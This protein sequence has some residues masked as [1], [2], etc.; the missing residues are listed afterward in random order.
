MSFLNFS[1]G[2]E[3]LDNIE[4]PSIEDISHDC[5]VAVDTFTGASQVSVKIL[6]PTSRHGFGP[7]LTL[8]NSSGRRQGIFGRGWSLGGIP[9]IGID[10]ENGLPAY[11]GND[12]FASSIA[13]SL[14]FKRTAAGDIDRRIEAGF[15]VEIL[16]A[17]EE[18]PRLRFERWTELATGDVHWRTRDTVDTY[19]FYGRSPASRIA[20]P[21]N[22]RRVFQ[23]LPELSVSARGD[24][25]AYDYAA[26]DLLGGAGQRLADRSRRG[27]LAQRY[28]K[29][30][31]WGNHRPV[32]NA[33]GLDIET[34]TWSFTAVFDYGD[35]DEQEPEVAPE[36][37]WRI[38]PDPF[39]GGAAGFDLRTWR[40]CHR[41]L[42]FH[43]F[44]ALG[45]TPVLTNATQFRYDERPD[46][47]Q[48]IGIQ[49][50]G[51]R[52]TGAARRSQSSPETVFEYTAPGHGAAFTPVPRALEA[53]APA[54]HASSKTL[55]VDLLGEGLPGILQDDRSGWFFQRNLGGGRFASPVCVQSRPAHSLASVALGDFDVDGNINATVLSGQGAGTYSFDRNTETWSSFVP[56]QRMPVVDGRAPIERLDLT[57][58]GQADLVIRT[59]DGLRIHT[60]DGSRGF[61]KAARDVRL[62]AA[63]DGPAGQPPLG[64]D[65]QTDYL[66][67]DMTGD[68]LPDQVLVRTGMVAYWPNLGW[69]RFGAPVIMENAPLL[70]T[71]GRFAIDRVLL[72]DLD[73]SGTA[74]LI[75]LGEGRLDIWTN[76]AGNG[77]VTPRSLTGLPIID[78]FSVLDIIDIAGDGR[79]SL[80]WTEKRKGRT[81]SYQTL[82][83]SAGVPP[84]LIA[85][86]SNGMGRVDRLEYGYST[87]HY[88][89]DMAGQRAW[90]TRLPTH[91]VVVDRHIVEDLIGNT[92]QDTRFQYRNGVYS[93][94]RRRFAGFAEVDT[95]SADFILSDPGPLPSCQPLL[96][97]HFFDQGEGIGHAQ[98]YWQG[99]PE[100]VDLPAFEMD[101]SA[102]T[103]VIDPQTAVEARQSLR[104]RPLREEKFVVLE[105]GPASVPLAVAQTGYVVRIEQAAARAAGAR[106][107]RRLDRAVVACMERETVRALYEGVSNDPRVQHGLIL[108]RDLHGSVLVSTQ[109]AY[110][111]RAGVPAEDDAQQ[112]LGCVVERHDIR[113]DTSDTRHALHLALVDESF[114]ISGLAAPPS[115]YFTFDEARTLVLAAIATPVPHH[116]TPLAGQALRIGWVRNFYCNA[117]GDAVLPFGD[118]AH[119]A[120]LHHVETAAFSTDFAVSHYGAGISSRLPGLGYRDEFGHWWQSSQAQTYLD[121]DGFFL[122]SGTRLSDG[123]P[124][125]IAYDDAGLFPATVTDVFGAVSHTEYDYVALKPW[126]SEMPT[127]AWSETSFDALGIAVRRSHGGTVVDAGGATQAYGFEPVFDAAAI[128]IATALA[129]PAAALGDVAE[130]LLYDF[131]AF[132]RD[133]S[134]PKSVHLRATD[135]FHDGQ[136]GRQDSGSPPMI[137]VAYRDGFGD[138]I[139]TKRQ[140]EAGE[141]IARGGDG[142]VLLDGAGAPSLQVTAERWVASGWQRQNGKGETVTLFDPYFSDRVDFEDDDVLTSFGRPTRVFYD[143]L[144]RM[145]ETQLPDGAIER[146]VYGAW[147]KQHFDANDTI[148][149]SA[150]RL[151]RVN[152]PASHPERHAL[153]VT[154][155]HAST[156]D[157]QILDSEGREVRVQQ[158]DGLGGAREQRVVHTQAGGVDRT[159]DGRGIEVLRLMQDMAGRT[160][161]Q[162]LADV[163]E[164]LTLYD[165]RDNA[166]ET[167]DA[168]AVLRQSSFDALDRLVAVDLD[169]GSG[170]RRIFDVTFADD[171]A[172]AAVIARNLLGAPVRTRDEGGEHVLL[173]ARPDG[174]ATRSRMT[175][176]AD[177]TVDVD[178][179]GVVALDGDAFTTS[180]VFDAL[181]RPLQESRA[182]GSIV[183]ATYAQSGGLRR[184]TVRTTDGQVP[185]TDI[186]DQAAYSA[187]GLRLTARLGNGVSLSRTYDPDTLLVRRILAER[188]AAGGRPPLL[189]DLRYSY[190]PVGNITGTEDLAHSATARSV[191]GGTPGASADR[192]YTYDAYYRLIQCTGRAHQAF[193]GSPDVLPNLPLSDGSA[194]EQFTQTY[195]Y[196]PAN[197]LTRLR[198]MG[199]ASNFTTDFWVDSASNRSRPLL[200]AGG[201][202]AA[203]PGSDFRATGEMRR[204]DH[205]EALTWRH[206]QRLVRAVVIDRSAD[207][208]PDD[209]ELYLYDSGGTRLRKVTRRLLG[210]DAVERIEVTYLAGA[211]RRRIFR[212]DTLILERFVT[213]LSDGFSDIAELHRWS[214]DTTGRETDDPT[215]TRVRYVLTDHLGSAMLRLDE[216]S[217]VISYEEVMPYGQTAFASGDDAREA[218]LKVYGFIGRERDVATGFH[219]IGQRYYSSWLC[220]WISPDPA[221]HTDGSNQYLY[222]QANP[223]TNLD[224]TGLQ[225]TT[226]RRPGRI[227][228]VRRSA[229]ADAAINAALPNQSPEIQV[230]YMFGTIAA[231]VDPSGVVHFGSRRDMNARAEADRL[232]GA[233][234]AIIGGGPGT[235]SGTSAGGGV[236]GGGEPAKQDAPSGGG[237][238]EAGG[239]T[240]DGDTPDPPPDPG[241]STGTEQADGTGS[242]TP[243]Q[244]TQ[245]EDGEGDSREGD[246]ADSA[247]AE[248]EDG[249]PE[250]DGAVLNSDATGP[251]GGGTSTDRHAHGQGDTGTG[252][253][254]GTGDPRRAGTGRADSPAHRPGGTGQGRGTNPGGSP[255][256]QEDGTGSGAGTNPNARGTEPG[257]GPGG[258]PGG[259]GTEPGGAPGGGPGG[260]AG[261]LP[262]GAPDGVPTGATEGQPGQGPEG[263]TADGTAQSTNPGEGASGDGGSRSAPEGEREPE[264]G[265]RSTGGSSRGSANGAQQP[266][267]GDAS[268]EGGNAQQDATVMDHV[269]RAAGYWHLEFGS[270]E[271][272]ESGGIPGGMGSLNLGSWG[273]AAFVALTVVDVVL[274][275]ASFGGL[276]AL[277]V[278]LK[279][280]LKAI[281]SFGR[282]ALARV[283]AGLAATFSRQGAFR[284]LQGAFRLRNFI[285]NR[286][287]AFR[288][289][290]G[291]TGLWASRVPNGAREIGDAI[292]RDAG[293]AIVMP[294][295][296][297]RELGSAGR[298]RTRLAQ[299]YRVLTS[300]SAIELVPDQASVIAA[301]RR[302]GIGDNLIA[303]EAAVRGIPLVTSERRMAQQIASAVFGPERQQVLRQLYGRVNILGI[304][305]DITSAADL[306]RLIF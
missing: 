143:A 254:G 176:V 37:P 81:A 213:R 241:G 305:T 174:E 50:T 224:P 88:L 165:A 61:S 219:H 45:P 272:G 204:V 237:D 117:A 166:V 112:R 302:F 197:N 85:Q 252:S 66:F 161:W 193:T 109:F 187:H 101:A 168:S 131:D 299:Y 240:N 276:A 265:G 289:F 108:D 27:A 137:E 286:G 103:G 212:G 263:G 145:V 269:V 217:R 21:R 179:S 244:Q 235:G 172:D 163:G 249:D 8:N 92:S 67:A 190:D 227:K 255:G 130:V 170:A 73:G 210:D 28:P 245:S 127:G 90:S 95:T 182:D 59:Q 72:A 31:R 120:R 146:S 215:T 26:E 171:P 243:A 19:T 39:S 223:V 148:D 189:Q 195:T 83:L 259:T 258:R 234:I 3:H 49:R 142:A 34:E 123:R 116:Q 133:G 128:D 158:S 246:G 115:G 247:A 33:A 30:I 192:R 164:T 102:L 156:P 11:D 69:G 76:A 29:S 46:G 124:V 74:D 275:V 211:E 87:R 294:V 113:H 18:G 208:R 136:G 25:I 306:A 205:L 292:L 226:Q 196:D 107:N 121:E 201:V 16:I 135:I 287:R 266:G 63:S 132:E 295:Q 270:D 53:T 293:N 144:G 199:V 98:R 191:F 9:T 280:G 157:V 281:Q 188:S 232:R 159:F 279:A 251:G 242:E 207:G 260:G 89:E 198:H 105:D 220:R 277:K 180:V 70:E 10:T 284:A 225:T 297:L 114:S 264:G 58:D 41:I 300:R 7:A 56:F 147:S 15:S 77:F 140:V 301:T 44:D 291:D 94:Q 24:A 183:V 35:H 14:V 155:P 129:D 169:T 248:D 126:R 283:T 185:E 173:D 230:G 273:Q 2:V 111:R 36:G 236:G 54:G 271:P 23:W 214:R 22:P 139:L 253:G 4:P 167:T 256:G 218:A 160:V 209:D 38:R 79:M 221:G 138:V 296:V 154:L 86:V 93:E 52:G 96:T 78:R 186:L 84:G 274:T 51:F 75:Y 152:L 151:S 203:N 181:G 141:A 267:Q 106:R 206:D 153:D 62:A 82:A 60:A 194:T 71:G 285:F 48:L 282:R 231:Y 104:G 304:G 17:R 119:P 43:R 184:M 228:R 100:A 125:T 110:P 134:P 47:T 20:D 150:W 262:G 12:G 97:R 6:L 178:W 229:T 55:L 68:G 64:S 177:A 268:G 175:L 122:P 257:G 40:L 238:P 149:T 162:R 5:Q 32:A 202:V 288:N 91:V 250:G 303:T 13:G 57:G 216:A 118:V 1:F 298:L 233:D 261:G 99:D 42:I 278:S 290:V 200:D 222:A 80:V 65:A 239:G